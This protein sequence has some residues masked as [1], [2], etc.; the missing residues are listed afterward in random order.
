MV[1]HDANMDLVE[2]ADKVRPRLEELEGEP[3]KRL[4][5]LITSAVI[6]DP[7]PSDD[8]VAALQV[9][10]KVLCDTAGE[11]RDALI[12][13]FDPGLHSRCRAPLH[14]KRNIMPILTFHRQ[15]IAIE[16]LED[17]SIGIV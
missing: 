3:P 4:A 6:A 15:K 8:V 16:H 9:G 17:L 1:A 7:M 14:H 5:M 11:G 13:V 2:F 12:I 10:S